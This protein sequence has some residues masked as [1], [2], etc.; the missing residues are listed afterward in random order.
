M[1]MTRRVPEWTGVSGPIGPNARA[2]TPAY[3]G[4]PFH[5]A[6]SVRASLTTCRFRIKRCLDFEELPTALPSPGDQPPFGWRRACR[7]AV[8]VLEGNQP[9]QASRTV[10]AMDRIA[11]ETTQVLVVADGKTTAAVSN[12]RGHLLEQFVAQLLGALGYEEPRTDRL[13]VTSD[14]IEIDVEARQ[15]VTGQPLIAECKAYSANVSAELLS[16]FLGKYGVRRMK[17]PNLVGLF[18]ALPRLTANGVEQAAEAQAVYPAFRHLGSYEIVEL[19][20]K[21]NLLPPESRGPSPRT[22]LTVVISEHGLALAAKALDVKSRKATK[23]VVWGTGTVSDPLLDLVDRSA[24]ADGL[25]VVREG[26]EATAAAPRAVREPPTIIA[27]RGSSAD[28]EYQLPA[29]PKYF[30]GRKSVA[31]DLGRRITETTQGQTVVINAKSGWGKSSLALNLASRVEKARGVS[32]VVDSRTAD[33]VDFVP[34]VLERLADD[35]SR[36]RVLDL[37]DDAAF[38]SLAAAVR[39]LGN[40]QTRG[41]SKPLLLFFD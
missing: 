30:V 37:P 1:S 27:V 28:F 41:K 9:S 5:T 36:K 22:D 4:R 25:A 35:A 20:G 18:V 19:L 6:A 33:R 24:L 2:A 34:A 40:S 7:R 23:V 13:N 26:E 17:D 21:A 3:K 8:A 12:K 31:A 29:A 14:G 15:K 10:A 39:T 16:V 32:L 38:S 11:V